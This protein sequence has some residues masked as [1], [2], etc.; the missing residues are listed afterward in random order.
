MPHSSRKNV[1][2]DSQRSYLLHFCRCPCGWGSGG[3]GLRGDGV[4][5]FNRQPGTRERITQL[6]ISP[7]STQTPMSPGRSAGIR[8]LHFVGGYGRNDPA[9]IR[10]S[11]EIWKR[12][13][14]HVCVDRLS[15]FI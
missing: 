15:V 6:I 4:A 3:E 11:D 7:A 5:E 14:L 1:G 2:G 8:E 13:R 10:C 9:L 12:A